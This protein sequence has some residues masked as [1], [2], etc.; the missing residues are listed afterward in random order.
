MAAQASTAKPQSRSMLADIV[1]SIFTPGTNSG[2]IRA[3]D[4]S[5]Y[6]L[7]AVLVVMVV[8]TRGNG[9]ICA[10]FALSVGLFASIKWFLVQ[11]AEAE[12]QHR[13]ERLAKEQEETDA[14]TKGG[15]AQ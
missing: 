3:M 14:V 4:M 6:A 9:H 5:F 12:E 7:F 8:L 15:K 1:D 13:R 11:I 2:L 10:L